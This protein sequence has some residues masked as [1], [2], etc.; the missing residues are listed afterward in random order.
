MNRLYVVSGP[1]KGYRDSPW[2]RLGARRLVHLPCRAM[3]PCE[4]ASIII[5][6]PESHHVSHQ[7]KRHGNSIEHSTPQPQFNFMSVI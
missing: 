7:M 1:E 6:G 2:R 3:C 4:D 5:A